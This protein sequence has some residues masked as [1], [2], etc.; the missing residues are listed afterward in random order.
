[1][2]DERIAGCLAAAGIKRRPLQLGTLVRTVQDAAA[3]LGVSE[4]QVAKAILFQ[5]GAEFALFVAAGDNKISNRK[6]RKLLGA[7]SVRIALPEIVLA[8]T[9]YRVGAVSPLGLL[10]DVPVYIDETL[11][12]YEQIYAG[13]GSEQALLPLAYRELLELTGGKAVDLK[14][15]QEMIEMS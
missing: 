4:G 2:G 6:V 8:V 15:D 11:E 14:A 5:A 10:T 3:A 1:M 12:R 7:K 13:G 9:G